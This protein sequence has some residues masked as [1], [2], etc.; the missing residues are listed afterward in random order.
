MILLRGL[1]SVGAIRIRTVEPVVLLTEM[2]PVVLADLDTRKRLASSKVLVLVI[3]VVP[4]RV[5]VSAMEIPLVFRPQTRT[6]K[7]DPS[8]VEEESTSMVSSAAKLVVKP[9]SSHWR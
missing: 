2:T 7:P 1:A 9:V 5:S 4:F 6:L 3:A 8:L